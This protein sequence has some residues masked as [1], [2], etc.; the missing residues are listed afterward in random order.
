ME[1]ITNGTDTVNNTVVVDDSGEENCR[2]ILYNNPNCRE[3]KYW[4]FIQLARP[5]DAIMPE[6]GWKSKHAIHMFCHKCHKF[7][8]FM[9]RCTQNIR[10]HMTR[11]HS[12]EMDEYKEAENKKA[13]ARKRCFEDGLTDLES[14]KQMRTADDANVENLTALC[15][16]WI[17][18]SLRPISIVEDQGLKAIVNLSVA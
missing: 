1:K 11:Y 14:S 3:K 10:Y 16:D 18:T 13:A 17:C 9:L 8:P 6:R 5:Y 12:K 7:M 2:F 15:A 4:Q